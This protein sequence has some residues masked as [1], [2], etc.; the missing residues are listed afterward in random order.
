MAS[1]DIKSPYAHSSSFDEGFLQVS[2]IH[3]LHYEQYGKTDGKPVIFLHGGPGGSTSLSNTLYF[4]PD[5]YRVVLFDQRGAGKSTPSA[6]IK[7]NTTDHL[8]NDIETLRIHLKI[9]KW[10]LVF[11]GSWG[12]ALALLYAQNHPEMVGSLIL[13]GILACRKIEREWSRG[14]S[15]A[16]RIYP[17]EYHKFLS[18]LPESER[19]DPFKGYYKYLLSDDKSTRLAA[20][21]EWN[22]WD[23][24]IGSLTTDEHTFEKL[25]DEKWLLS[26]ALLEAHYFSHAAWL[27]DEQILFKQNVDKIRHIPTTLVQG[28]YDIICAPQTAWE[29]HNAWPESRLIWIADAGHSA[30][31]PGT[32]SKLIE[33]CDEYA[34][35]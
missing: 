7:E 5:I 4:N 16:A 12:S 8:I 26:H 18:F 34:N 20:A 19:Q 22:R 27:T 23:M 14:D 35:L 13:R 21:K 30:K 3:R 24:T 15:G 11:G 32:Q 2:T 6:E 28:R 25:N 9:S 1:V 10:H 29:L 33:V 31:E 17:E